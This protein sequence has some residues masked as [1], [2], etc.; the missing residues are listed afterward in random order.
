MLVSAVVFAG[1]SQF[2]LIAVLA[3]PAGPASAIP[4]VLLMNARHLFYGPTLLARL[5]VGRPHLPLPLLSFGLTD[6]VLAVA[7]ARVDR[8]PQADREAWFVWVQTGAYLTWVAGTTAGAMLGQEIPAEWT[9]L[10]D[11]LAFVLPALFLALAC[12][13]ARGTSPVVVAGAAVVTA[14]ALSAL[15]A[16]WALVVGIVIGASLT[17]IRHGAERLS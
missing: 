14:A 17:L 7:L 4:M 16:H 1:A 11:G 2:L 13:V 5:N 15:P 10:R 9:I 6:E 8:I 3:S 12:D